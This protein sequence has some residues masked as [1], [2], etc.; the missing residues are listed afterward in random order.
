MRIF[1]LISALATFVT[2]VAG[3]AARVDTGCELGIGR[4]DVESYIAL[5]PVPPD[6]EIVTRSGV[7]QV[8]DSDDKRLGYISKNLPK[9]GQLIN[10][11]LYE[12]ALVVTFT[13][14]PTSAGYSTKL[15]LTA[16][17][18]FDPSI[19][20]GLLFSPSLILRT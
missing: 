17:V 20:T 2:T 19:I 7:I 4:E 15:Y 12:N 6:P 9:D 11:P 16:T 13:T 14:A 5:S 10:D 3:A 8:V 1:A 18:C